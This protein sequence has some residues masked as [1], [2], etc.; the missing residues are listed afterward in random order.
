MV[1]TTH[2]IKLIIVGTKTDGIMNQPQK[3][4][5]PLAAAQKKNPDVIV[6]HANQ[7]AL[8]K[9]QNHQASEWLHLRCGLAVENMSGDTEILVHP[10]KCQRVI[11]DLKAAGFLVTNEKEALC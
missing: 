2:I 3:E 6:T 5:T 8:F 9:A 11:A 4:K 1:L 7:T 10:R